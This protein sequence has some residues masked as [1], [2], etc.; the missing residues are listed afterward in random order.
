MDESIRDFYYFLRLQDLSLYI[1]K[2]QKQSQ[3]FVLLGSEQN[4]F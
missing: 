3:F 2:K 4:V 1:L